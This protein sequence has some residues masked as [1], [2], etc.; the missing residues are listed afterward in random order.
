MSKITDDDFDA[1]IAFLRDGDTSRCNYLVVQLA[2][3]QVL[4]VVLPI[5]RR[6]GIPL[7][8]GDDIAKF[9]S[10]L[11]RTELSVLKRS[12]E[13]TERRTVRVPLSIKDQ[14]RARAVYAPDGNGRRTLR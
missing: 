3:G 5:L 8:S 11:N 12:A 7:P 10:E 1:A 13:K 6:R 2:V 14:A 4:T 9:L